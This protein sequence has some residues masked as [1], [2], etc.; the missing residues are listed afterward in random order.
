MSTDILLRFTRWALFLGCSAAVLLAPHYY[1]TH[2]ESLTQF[3]AAGIRRL[4]LLAAALYGCFIQGRAIIR[5]NART[6][7]SQTHRRD[8]P[9]VAAD[10]PKSVAH[11]FVASYRSRPVLTGFLLLYWFSLPVLFALISTDKGVFW[12]NALIG[13]LIAGVLL[14]VVSYRLRR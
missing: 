14:L 7:V 12:R 9:L 8:E 10:N 5:D 2:P 3:D 13:E 6:P 11:P 4:A 1:F